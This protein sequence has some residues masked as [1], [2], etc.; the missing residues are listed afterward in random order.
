MHKSKVEYILII[1]AENSN[2]SL[3]EINHYVIYFFKKVGHDFK[4]PEHNFI[5]TEK[6]FPQPYKFCSEYSCETCRKIAESIFHNPDID[7]L[8]YE[9]SELEAKLKEFVLP[10]GFW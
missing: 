2:L 4:L 6:D 9:L 5:E 7:G 3:E 8:E 10:K 1:D